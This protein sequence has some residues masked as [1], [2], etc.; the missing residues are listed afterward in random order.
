MTLASDVPTLGWF[1]GS[2]ELNQSG[3][4]RMCFPLWRQAIEEVARTW[5]KRCEADDIGMSLSSFVF[6]A[7]G[8][9][10]GSFAARSVRASGLVIDTPSTLIQPTLGAGKGD[11]TRYGLIQQIA[12]AFDSKSMIMVHP[13]EISVERIVCGS[14]RDLD[15]RA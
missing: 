10:L 9:D 6:L 8:T 3:M 11:K 15:Y 13:S 7:K 4:N 2:P 12:Q 1:V 5:K 14:Q